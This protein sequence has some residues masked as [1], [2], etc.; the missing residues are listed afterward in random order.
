M[1]LGSTGNLA[2]GGSLSIT[3]GLTITASNINIG[4][5]SLT[6]ISVALGGVSN[7]VLGNNSGNPIVMGVNNVCIGNQIG[8]AVNSD[9]GFNG[10]NCTFI[11]YNTSG[12]NYGVNAVNST[13]IGANARFTSTNQ[14][15]LG[16]TSETVVCPNILTVNGSLSVNTPVITDSTY[17]NVGYGYGALASGFT[18]CGSQNVAIGWQ[19]GNLLNSSSSCNVFVGLQAGNNATSVNHCTYIGYQA[20]GSNTQTTGNWNTFV[21]YQSGFSIGTGVDNACFGKTS[22]QAITSGSRNTFIGTSAGSNAAT[23]NNSTAIG[24]NSQISANNQVVL[25]TATEIVMCP[26]HLLVAANLALTSGC[27]GIK[28]DGTQSIYMTDVAGA[29]TTSV[30]SYCR[31]FATGGNAYL[32]FYGNRYWRNTGINGGGGGGYVM[33][34]GP[35]GNLNIAGNLIAAG[36]LNATG[37]CGINSSS[38]NCALDVRPTGQVCTTAKIWGGNTGSLS[39]YE[40]WSAGWGGGLATWDIGCATIKMNGY[41]TR[42]DG[43]KKRDIR[44]IDR[45]LKE[46][47]QLR[48]VKYKWKEEYCYRNDKDEDFTGFIAQEVEEIIPEMIEHDT[49]GFKSIKTCEF[50]PL[51][52]QSIQELNEIIIKQQKQIDF[53]MSK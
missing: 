26:N 51:I 8:T 35:T 7:I 38:P 47:L 4:N 30:N 3:G 14:I 31:M 33:T 52:I 17:K 24:Y 5:G 13:A 9:T 22:G 44:N 2:I 6:N 15:M 1:T 28:A 45:G 42:S 34:L 46:I 21:G 27:I 41:V 19:A 23:Y 18:S 20:G 53:L 39:V 10:S 12:Y 48:V 16:T 36:T 29:F 50:T 40:D 25:G 43:R 11:G 49:D 32:D 37:N